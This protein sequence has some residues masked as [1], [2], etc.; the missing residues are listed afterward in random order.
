MDKNSNELLDITSWKRLGAFGLYVPSYVDIVYEKPMENVIAYVTYKELFP[1]ED[2][3]IKSIQKQFS[4]YFVKDVVQFLC[5]MNYIRS[6]KYSNMLDDFPFANTLLEKVD[7]TNLHK[8]KGKRRFTSRQLFLADIKLALIHGS[9]DIKAKFAANNLEEITKLIFRPS[10]FLESQNEDTE[11]KDL[12]RL[13][14]ARNMVFNEARTFALDVARYSYIFNVLGEALK[15]QGKKTLNKMFEEIVGVSFDF[16]LSVGFGIWG[17]YRTDN[18]EDRLK[19]PEEFLFSSNYFRNT[20]EYTR[21]NHAKALKG[22][23][24]DFASIKEA[25]I[26]DERQNGELFSFQ[27][28][29]KNPLIRDGETYY[30]IDNEFF[31]RRLT[32]GAFW[33]IFDHAKNNKER[34]A[35]RGYWGK[36]FEKYVLDLTL[37]SYG[38][39][40]T[41]S[42]NLGD[43][44]ADIDVVVY[45]P[46]SII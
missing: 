4:E 41:F 12:V 31:E 13:L 36:L 38:R 15:F 34:M 6:H 11:D 16:Y 14:M 32:E 23:S 5:K 7:R 17:F 10:D 30:L 24:S 39:D 27:P 44:T 8:Y 22:I 21:N 43:D 45:Y 3:N 2:N 20:N 29:Y 1:G 19:S 9:S 25:L 46:N 18:F 42:E 33:H 26:A 28:F 40:R 35:L 37:S